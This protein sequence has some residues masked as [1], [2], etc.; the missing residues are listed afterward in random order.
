MYIYCVVCY[1]VIAAQGVCKKCYRV[2]AA[3]GVCK[4]CC[5]VIAAQGVCKKCCRVFT[6]HYTLDDD[7]DC[8]M[9]YE[10]FLPSS[11]FPYEPK[12]FHIEFNRLEM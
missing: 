9:D 8:P 7:L 3:Q 1:R 11:I 12:T 4:K 2:I 6:H 10:L 5:R